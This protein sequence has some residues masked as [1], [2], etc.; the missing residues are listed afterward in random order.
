[1]K[2]AIVT[3]ATGFLGYVLTL[4]LT[5]NDTFVYA[6]CRKNSKNLSRLVG[7]NNLEIIEVDFQNKPVISKIN[8]DVF[9]HFAWEGNRSIFAEQFKN[10][11]NTLN[12]I[13]LAT[14]F[15]CKRFLCAGSQAEYG[16]RDGLIT[17]ETSLNPIDAYGACKVATYYLAANYAKQLNIELTWLRLFSIY[18]P[19]D[20]PDSLISML[21]KELSLNNTFIIKSNGKHI[22]NYL[23][24]E[25][26]ARAMRLLGWQ[27]Q[28]DTVYNIASKINRPL[29]EYIDEVNL[30]INPN[31][32]IEYGNENCPVNLNVTTDKLKNEIGDYEQVCFK[33]AFLS[34]I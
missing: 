34:N 4:E 27:S 1:L 33:N 17:E 8:A 30:T 32:K 18:G 28:S 16:Y 23:H 29:F 11:Q 9:Y 3:G 26:A 6:L 22:W 21:T 15:G 31:Q 12:C 14:E 24:E 19:N 5:N 10:I 2:K 25:D 7:I 13:E 20:R